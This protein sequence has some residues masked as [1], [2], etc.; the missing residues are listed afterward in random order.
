MRPI[1][2]DLGN[3]PGDFTRDKVTGRTLFMST[4]NGTRAIVAAQSATLKLVGALVNAQTV[5]R[6]LADQPRDVTFI[7]SG[8]QGRFSIED[9]LG[10]GAMISRLSA[11]TSVETCETA[12]RCVRDFENSKATLPQVLR[13]GQGGRNILAAGLE[14]DIDFAARLDVF[15]VVGEVRKCDSGQ[16]SVFRRANSL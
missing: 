5:A 6:M 15:D 16:I 1:D 7:C 10:A 4:T 13:A 2:F 12:E 11:L 3:S 8:T 14:P 9:A